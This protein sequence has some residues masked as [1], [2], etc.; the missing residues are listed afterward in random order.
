MEHLFVI[1]DKGDRLL[2]S[3]NCKHFDPQEVYKCALFDSE[4]E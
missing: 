3:E 2:H 4:S 1:L